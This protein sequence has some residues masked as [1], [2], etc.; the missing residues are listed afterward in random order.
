MGQEADK[1][2]VS[3]SRYER[4]VRAREEA[5]RLLEA[6]SRELFEANERL[7]Q[8]AADLE[9]Q[10]QARTAKL[11]QALRNAEE[12][13][14]LRSRFLAVMSHEIRTPL[15]GI[16]GMLD[17]LREHERLTPNGSERIDAAIAS[18]SS[19]HRIVNDVLDLSKLDAGK[20]CFA[21][22]AIDLRA[23]VQGIVELLEPKA[24]DRGLRFAVNMSDSVPA[25]FSGDATRMRQVLLNL[26]DNA[27]KF[28][29]NGTIM[30]RAYALAHEQ[31]RLRVEVVDQGVGIAAEDV[32]QL[33]IDFSQIDG[34]LAR[35]VGGTGLGLAIC[36]RI[37]GAMGGEIGVE[38]DVG[39]GSTFWLELPFI[40]LDASTAAVDM[41]MQ[42]LG[43]DDLRA[44]LFG[45]RVLI[46][47]DN[48]TNQKLV[49]AYAERVGLQADVVENGRVA[50]AYAQR[51][52]YDAI[53][54]DLAMPE[55][56]GISA[57][58]AIRKAEAAGQRARTPII[59]VT[60]HVMQSVVEECREVGMDDVVFKPISPDRLAGVLY[61]LI[62]DDRDDPQARS[63]LPDLPAWPEVSDNLLKVMVPDVLGQLRETFCDDDLR[64]MLRDF[65]DNSQA[66]LATMR[67]A[68][69]A[70][71][72]DVLTTETHAVKGAASMLGL[73]TLSE[74][75]EVMQ[76]SLAREDTDA[77]P[78][79]IDS[80]EEALREVRE[81][82]AAR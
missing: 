14:E 82:L 56:D 74:L 72:A 11:S 43:R 58:I 49:R 12:A 76:D 18:A 71:D 33:F 32:G 53:L 81:A 75:L 10:V 7:K 47:E 41:R 26:C 55:M 8:Q 57:T 3:R 17:L 68:L 78:D 25:R 21:K 2:T 20:M 69:L 80:L 73:R 24:R 46:A 4:A 63:A 61:K 48:P 36:K 38:S 51:Y 70:G 45:K 79:I 23:L 64:Q 13:T 44:Q 42:R 9:S 1:K 39:T 59:A 60:A 6:K 27:V 66:R 67:D 52:A 15:G 19:L 16:I 37:V 65:C 34:S 62:G 31:D 28:S 77:L 29:D 54:M 50:V 30:V 5:E 35:R 22:E 40:A